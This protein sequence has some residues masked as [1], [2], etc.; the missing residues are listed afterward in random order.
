MTSSMSLSTWSMP[1]MSLY[2]TPVVALGL[3]LSSTLNSLPCAHD[4]EGGTVSADHVCSG[5]QRQTHCTK[6]RQ[7][8]LNPEPHT[9]KRVNCS[10][11]CCM[12]L[13]FVRPIF[14]ST[15]SPTPTTVRSSSR[16]RIGKN[17]PAYWLRNALTLAVSSTT[18]SGTTYTWVVDYHGI[19]ET[20]FH[21]CMQHTQVM[22]S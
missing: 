7:S 17:W 20:F 5:Q 2:E 15:Q 13:F 9:L 3:P 16:P 1:A 21:C 10:A 14:F 12:V 18:N 6:C 8:L 19:L 11:A 22:Y 4:S